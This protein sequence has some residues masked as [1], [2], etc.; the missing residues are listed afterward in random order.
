MSER[1]AEFWGR[2]YQGKLKRDLL[3]MEFSLEDLKA[4]TPLNGKPIW[5]EHNAKTGNIGVIHR[6]WVDTQG[7][8]CIH[9]ELYGPDVIG[10]LHYQIR[11]KLVKGE[12]PDLS[13]HWV[14]QADAITDVVDIDTKAVIEA[15]LTKE[16][17]FKGTNLLSVAAHAYSK[18]KTL[19]IGLPGQ[20]LSLQPLPSMSQDLKT[21]IEEMEKLGVT[22]TDE[23][24]RRIAPDGTG[25]DGALLVLK[26]MTEMSDRK[27]TEFGTKELDI[28]R[29]ARMEDS[30]K[31]ELED[32]R[33]WREKA[34][35]SYATDQGKVAED[36][37]DSIEKRIPEADRKAI[38]EQIQVLSS[39]SDYSSAFNLLKLFGQS[40]IEQT[41]L[42]NDY[43][44]QMIR[45]KKDYNELLK[46]RNDMNDKN[47]TAVQQVEVTAHSMAV[48][49]GIDKSAETNAVKKTIIDPATK[50]VEQKASAEAAAANFYF[51]KAI[52]VTSSQHEFGASM[53]KM[54]EEGKLTAGTLPTV[55]WTHYL[56][57]NRGPSFNRD[58]V[59][60]FKD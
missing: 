10:D 55:D 53:D 3:N 56:G 59:I 33:A 2:L 42:A 9:G 58:G 17:A 41:K 22:F 11:E 57:Y 14:G 18:T 28:M 6:S 35:E 40:S 1:P 50:P 30:E 39:K 37:Y 13:I 47:A 32:L 44:K 21:T 24:V 43:S 25:V 31:K 48:K 15:S 60:P 49:R 8:L 51:A 38:K 27:N 5:L 16:G 19:H 46:E 29:K 7:W 45:G 54:V 52:G 36:L 26:K 20:R 4:M 12:L 34:E 23:E